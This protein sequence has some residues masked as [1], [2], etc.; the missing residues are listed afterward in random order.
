MKHQKAVIFLI[1]SIV[2]LFLAALLGFAIF[3]FIVG[4]YAAGGVLCALFVLG[5]MCGVG[6][7]VQN[8]IDRKCMSL[9]LSKNY[10]EEKNMLE[11]KMKSP[12]FFLYRVVALQHYA[13]TCAA[14]D[15]LATTRRYLDK[16]RRGG[17]K[18]W[19]YRTAYLYILIFLDEGN[20]QAARN[21]YEDFRRDCARAEV[22][23]KQLE[24]LKAIFQRLVRSRNVAPLPESAIE[25]AYPVVARILG[26][27][28]EAS[29][30]E[31]WK[32]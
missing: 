2:I 15:D 14:L 12:F 30:P 9:F 27:Q 31:E 24:V 4:E 25:S 3:S 8:Q 32:E 6:V 18:G 16:L 10:E 20:V 26:R 21:E 13:C 11:R 29:F 5:T 23:Q 17:G 7:I 28:Y 22:Y 1:S 19:K